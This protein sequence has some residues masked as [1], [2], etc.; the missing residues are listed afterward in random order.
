MVATGGILN[1]VTI[2]SGG[3]VIDSGSLVS[4]DFHDIGNDITV[5]NGNSA[6]KWRGTIDGITASIGG[7]LLAVSQT[8]NTKMLS[9][10]SRPPVMQQ[11]SRMIHRA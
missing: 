4:I 9:G 7:T 8:P 11:A 5:E 3:I 10:Q 6:V 2:E 1:S